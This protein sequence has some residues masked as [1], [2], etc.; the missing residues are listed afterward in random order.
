[1]ACEGS[2]DTETRGS[3]TTPPTLPS[4]A[5][6]RGVDQGS[7]ARLNAVLQ[8][9]DPYERAR[10][11]GELLPEL[12]AEAIPLVES[13][14]DRFRLHLGPVDFDLLIRFWAEHDPKAATMWTFKRASPVYKT[15]AS[16]TVIEVWAEKDP[17]GALVAA[18][19]ALRDADIEVARA[20]QMALVR[21]WFETD[22]PGLDRYIYDL[23]AGI[24]RQRAIFAYALT[25]AEREGSDALIR[26][27][28]AV[29]EDDPRYKASVYQ[30]VL[31]ALSWSDMEAAVRFCNAQCDGPF[32]GRL[33]N[34][35]I[36]TRLRNGDEGSEVVQWVA[37]SRPTEEER[38][39][40]WKQQLWTSYAQWAFK[41]REKAVEWMRE[42]LESEA[43]PDWTGLLVGEFARQLSV[44]SPGDAIRWAE[45][46]DDEGDRELT[47]IRI[48]RRWR[49]QDEAAAEAW[50]ADSPLSEQAR[51]RAR[52]LSQPDN[53]PTRKKREEE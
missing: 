32:G 17:A 19:N 13:V 48:A 29:P 21:G 24:H 12:D 11:L 43:P 33:R 50:L 8:S 10:L 18:E 14:L 47:L 6:A 51:T 2:Q 28:E 41:E 1:M 49:R 35:L 52:D 39:D 44:D 22:R 53:L 15:T 40:L 37:N 16:R 27:A 5:D 30:Q 26:W 4:A 42:M 34:V 23:G 25:V 31:S 38:L 36:G 7:E 9:R 3:Q 45:Q 46:I 20:V